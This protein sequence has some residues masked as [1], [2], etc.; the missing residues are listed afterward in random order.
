MV[1]LGQ[2]DVCP[3][4]DL[5]VTRGGQLQA[6]E[7]EEREEGEEGEEREKRGGEGATHDAQPALP[8]LKC[9]TADTN[10]VTISFG[11]PSE[12]S[13]SL[14]KGHSLLFD[15][16]AHGGHCLVSVGRHIKLIHSTC[17]AVLDTDY[18]GAAPA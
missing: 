8:A 1:L 5:Q 9:A 4:G 17:V 7:R 3:T 11:S 2:D 6:V 10:K 16:P 18:N 12:P 14:S 15:A 13:P